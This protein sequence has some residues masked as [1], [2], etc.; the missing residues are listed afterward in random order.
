MSNIILFPG[1]YDPVHNGHLLMA[2]RAAEQ[3][4]A[5]VIIVPA[6]VSIWKN[7]SVNPLDKLN[8]LKIAVKNEKNVSIDTYELENSAD[9]IYSYQ[10]VRH[11]KEVYPDD[12][13]YL[14]IGSDQVK[15]FHRWKEAE[16]ISRSVQIIY[17]GRHNL[18]DGGNIEKYHMLRVE[19]DNIDMESSSIRNL[20]RADAPREVLHYIEEH[21]LYYIPKIKSLMSEKR[22]QHTLRVANLA[23]DI[24]LANNIPNPDKCYVAGLLH[25]IAK[26]IDDN[27]MNE[28][29]DKYYPEFKDLPLPIYHQFIG[30]DMAKYLFNIEDR[31]ILSPIFFHTTGNVDSDGKVDMSIY[32]KILYCADKI[33][34]GR[35]Y[36][37]KYMIDA[38]LKDIYSGFDLTY[39]ENQKYLKERKSVIK[40][41]SAT[42]PD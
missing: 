28:L 34:P 37:S 16:E 35:G 21:E 5:R 23:L 7:E 3:F 30:K 4:D 38:C 9:S 20:Q 2:R 31:D 22:Y 25:D 41:F 42:Y 27:R 10:T 24:A 6:K 11:F 8:M 14:L 26:G 15:E 29:M 1:N 13:L 12:N 18:D 36:D 40:E 39:S 32:E 33:E 17:Y 19:G